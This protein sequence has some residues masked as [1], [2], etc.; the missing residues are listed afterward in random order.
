MQHAGRAGQ[1]PF[2][3]AHAILL[4]EQLMFQQQKA[5]HWRK[6]GESNTDPPPAAEADGH[7]SENKPDDVNDIAG[8]KPHVDKLPAIDASVL[9]AGKEW[10]KSVEHYLCLWIQ[11]NECCHNLLDKYFGN[12]QWT[13]KGVCQC[14]SQ[15]HVS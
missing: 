12:P 15:P 10:K 2:L 7:K 1:N 6:M 13:R 11:T 8:D 9:A 4:V 14:C 3:N 5:K